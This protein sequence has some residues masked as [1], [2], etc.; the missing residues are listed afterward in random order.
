MKQVSHP[1]VL[2][3]IGEFFERETYHLVLE[4]CE[5]GDLLNFLKK[6]KE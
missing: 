1:N 5:E 4:Y 6:I 2:R 3:L